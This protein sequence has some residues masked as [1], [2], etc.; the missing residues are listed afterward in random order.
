MGFRELR[1][2]VVIEAVR[3]MLMAEGYAVVYEGR[4]GGPDVVAYHRELHELVV[5]EA[6]GVPTRVKVRGPDRGRPKRF[7]TIRNQFKY[8]PAKV[9]AELMDREYEWLHR[10]A[11][12]ARDVVERV[13]ASELNVRYVGV[14]GYDEGYLEVLDRRERAISRLGYEVWLIDGESR[15]RHRYGGSKVA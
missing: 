7:S 6:K 1:E 3:R 4:R 13:G 10:S 12:W 11:P 15:V 8:W 14:L 5:V 9:I 2:D